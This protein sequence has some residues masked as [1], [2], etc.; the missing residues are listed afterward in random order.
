MSNVSGPMKNV[1]SR[2]QEPS[3]GR[4]K[5]LSRLYPG[6]KNRMASHS[7][8]IKAELRFHKERPDSEAT[9]IDPGVKIPAKAFDALRLRA[10]QLA[11]RRGEDIFDPVKRFARAIVDSSQPVDDHDAL[12][13]WYQQIKLQQEEAN[14]VRYRKAAAKKEAQEVEHANV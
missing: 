3:A 1:L 4:Q 8:R 14:K 11:F 2:E 5:L 6:H 13:Q 10:F 9:F 12:D 7:H